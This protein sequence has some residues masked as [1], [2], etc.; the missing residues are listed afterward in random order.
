MT[1]APGR[2]PGGSA[3]AGTNKLPTLS[4]LQQVSR[5]REHFP[6]TWVWETI[7]AGYGCLF[8]YYLA[9]SLTGLCFS[10]LDQNRYICNIVDSDETAHNE[11]SNQDLH[12][13]G[14]K[15]FIDIP[16]YNSKCDPIK[17]WKC[18]F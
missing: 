9:F 2:Y 10:L 16:N 13:F 12:W 11:L 1:Y 4:S 6:E 5:T 17:R 18:P 3:G 8:L 15:F 7:L 14:S